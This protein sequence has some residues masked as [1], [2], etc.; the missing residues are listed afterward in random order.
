M[1]ENDIYCETRKQT[2]IREIIAGSTDTPDTY[3]DFTLHQLDQFKA[4]IAANKNSQTID[5]PPRSTLDNK[6]LTVGNSLLGKR[7]GET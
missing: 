3:Q 4:R 6:N 1:S 2:L 5:Q 7:Q